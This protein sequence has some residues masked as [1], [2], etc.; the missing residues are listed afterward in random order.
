[1]PNHTYIVNSG[2]PPCVDR[3]NEDLVTR[4]H[5]EPP[6]S[7]VCCMPSYWFWYDF[8]WRVFIANN[9]IIGFGDYAYVDFRKIKLFQ[10]FYISSAYDV[11]LS[12][13]SLVASAIITIQEFH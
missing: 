13:V 2:A 11:L 10:I 6:L 5:V 7:T 8:K 3:A 4:Q 9:F 1:M 12:F